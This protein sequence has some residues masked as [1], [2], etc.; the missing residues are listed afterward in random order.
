MHDN[1]FSARL[2][3]TDTIR[4]TRRKH[5]FSRKRRDAAI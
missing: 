1:K 4:H 3:M 2:K 5:V